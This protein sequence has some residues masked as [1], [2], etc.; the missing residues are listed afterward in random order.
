MANVYLVLLAYLHVGCNMELI[1][2]REPDDIKKL[3]LAIKEKLGSDIESDSLAVWSFNLL[4]KY[5]W[6]SWR[7]ELKKLGFTWQKFLKV[8][9]YNTND[10]VAWAITGEMSWQELI[11]KIIETIGRYI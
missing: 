10:M 1:V 2:P 6:D 7:N 5:L 9:R 3:I 8:L 4:P 11:N